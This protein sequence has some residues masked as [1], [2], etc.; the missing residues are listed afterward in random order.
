MTIPDLA[1][2]IQFLLGLS[3]LGISLDKVITLLESEVH[4]QQLADLFVIWADEGCSLA[5]IKKCFLG[6]REVIE[7]LLRPCVGHMFELRPPQPNL[8]DIARRVV[9]WRACSGVITTSEKDLVDRGFISYDFAEGF[10]DS[11]MWRD[12]EKSFPGMPYRE[13]V[14]P[15]EDNLSTRLA[16]S[17]PQKVRDHLSESNGPQLVKWV[18]SAF[19]ITFAFALGY[20]A[21]SQNPQMEFTRIALHELWLKGNYP[22][23]FH[24]KHGPLV[25]LCASL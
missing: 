9:R 14:K 4:R 13:V 5:P 20:A 19:R 3:K 7:Q 21:L 8:Q 2:E 25:V 23:G 12:L 18:A 24:G 15:W 16:A 10:V 6:R 1:S 17:I 22:L 11:Q